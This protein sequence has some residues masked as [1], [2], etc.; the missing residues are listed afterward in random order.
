MD[1]TVFE[2]IRTHRG[3]LPTAFFAWATLDH[4]ERLN[5]LSPSK[6]LDWFQI[7]FAANS[8]GR[9]F[10]L[11]ER[12]LSERLED[13][14]SISSGKLM[15]TDQLGIK[16][17]VCKDPNFDLKSIKRELLIRAYRG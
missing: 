14:E 3:T 2:I 13:V 12:D 16:N 1:S 17:L 11:S 4:W 15:W 9:V 10:K 5:E 7:S 6:S 8:P